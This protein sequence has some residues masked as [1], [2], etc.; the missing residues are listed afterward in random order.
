MAIL[1]SLWRLCPLVSHQRSA[2]DLL[3]RYSLPAPDP[4]LFL[5]FSQ[6]GFLSLCKFYLYTWNGWSKWNLFQSLQPAAYSLQFPAPTNQKYSNFGARP[7]NFKICPIETTAVPRVI[8]SFFIRT[9]KFDLKLAVLK[10]SSIFSLK[11]S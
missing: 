4:Y 2:V 10:Y 8:H 7:K 9:S 11:C 3:K 6:L 5:S 1:G